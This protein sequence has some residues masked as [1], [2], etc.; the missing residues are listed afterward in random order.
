VYAVVRTG[1]RQYRVSEGD[2]VDV[3]KLEQPKGARIELHDVL[4]AVDG[5]DV[6]VGKPVLEGARVVA[7]VVS[8]VKDDKVM[9]YKYKRTKR[10][11][12]KQGH[13]QPLTRIKIESIH[14]Q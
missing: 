10:Y 13:R 2:V 14:L 5:D 11:R 8:Q 9:V 3:E 6:H 12:R 4:L 1:G 7:R